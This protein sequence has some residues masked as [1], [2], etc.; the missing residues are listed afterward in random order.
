MQLLPS[1]EEELSASERDAMAA[2]S[3]EEQESEARWQE[4]FA[5]SEELLGR[6]SEQA[7]AEF[8]RGETRPL[9]SKVLPRIDADRRG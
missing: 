9:A 8:E 4:L 1:R 3:L 2:P 5:R 6:L 7:I